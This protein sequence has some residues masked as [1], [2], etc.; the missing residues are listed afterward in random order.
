MTR[1]TT[2]V[3]MID[4]HNSYY[5]DDG[6]RQLLG[7]PP[8]WRLDETVHAC[9]EL[10]EHARS[11]GMPVIYTRNRLRDDLAD[12]MPSHAPALRRGRE[13]FTPRSAPYQAWKG[14][15]M[16]ELA[17]EPGDVVIDKLRWCAFTYTELDPILRNLG[18][19][20]LIVAGLQTNVCIESTVR[21]ALMRN[22]LV[23][24]AVDAV[25]TDGEKLHW[26]ALDAMRV[27]YAEV[28]PWRELVDPSLPWDRALQLPQYGRS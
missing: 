21:S 27:L 9:R 14:E 8:I 4:M 17:P 1:P 28:A 12:V 2:A 3:L 19:S 6:Y 16:D 23:G 15:I 13:Q 11:S 5:A 10:L 18:V 22:F 26:N 20:R 24:V 7:Y 25:S